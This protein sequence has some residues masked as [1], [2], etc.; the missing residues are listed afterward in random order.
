MDT[1]YISPDIG[2][3]RA[4][5]CN[6]SYFEGFW[7]IE[8]GVSVNSYIL[9]G[10]KTALVDL[11]S[12]WE[13]CDEQ[14][15]NQ[16]KLHGIALEDLDILVMN[17]MECDHT[18]CV[19]DLMKR[20]KKLHI[21]CTEKAAALLKNFVKLEEADCERIKTV[22]NGDTL[23]LGK[24][25]KSGSELRFTF[26]ETPNI[27]WPETMMTYENSSKTLFSCDAF[28]SYGALNDGRVFDDEFSEEEHRIFEEECL[29]YYATVIASFGV[30]VK[31]GLA[32]LKELNIAVIAPSH[33]MVWRKNPAVM[34]AR[35]EKYAGY[36]TGGDQ[37]KRICV[38]SGSMYGNT[39]RGTEALIDGIKETGVPYTL[40]NIPET[41]LS[42]VAAQALRSKGLALAFPTYEYKMYP[43]AVHVLDM[44]AR[45]HIYNKTVARI[46]SWGWSGGAQKEYEQLTA[47][48]RWTNLESLEWQGTAN[49]QNL[50]GL[51]A[52]GKKLAESL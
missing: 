13:H 2:V 11:Y 19:A 45:K 42:Q 10:E 40:L 48:L 12:E 33:G 34:V 18:A 44:F 46:G 51:K 15:E 50:A 3:L 32:K 31:N 28:G 6:A 29:L 17:H 36:N 47:A 23:S 8:R 49:T 1:K 41:P 52:L 26:Y 37:E 30:P 22:K 4:N 43:P 25:I 14:I 21:Y 20:N 39:A 16:L 7:K 27:H 38:I 5:I 9:T 24:G 35:F